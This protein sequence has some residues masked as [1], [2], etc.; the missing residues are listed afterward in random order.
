MTTERTG[1]P[2][3][4]SHFDLEAERRKVLPEPIPV[5][6]AEPRLLSEGRFYVDV[7]GLLNVVMPGQ[8][9]RAFTT[10]WP[11]GVREP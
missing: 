5:V 3:D 7:H 6:V 8:K 11:V 4:W 2:D 10:G 1:P 9:V